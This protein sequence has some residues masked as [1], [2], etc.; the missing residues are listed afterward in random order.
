MDRP[1]SPSATG[2]SDMRCFLSGI[3]QEQLQRERDEVMDCTPEDVCRLADYV[4]CILDSGLVCA[5]GSSAK[6]EED[7]DVFLTIENLMGG[8]AS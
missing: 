6:I 4:Q 8:D 7:R 5:V 2:A 1:L 3:T